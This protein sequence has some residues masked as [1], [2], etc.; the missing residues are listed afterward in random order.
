M[1]YILIGTLVINSIALVAPIN[2]APL[3]DTN[4]DT[5]AWTNHVAYLEGTG[6]FGADHYGAVLV[7]HTY[8]PLEDIVN[9]TIGDEIRIYDNNNYHYYEITQIETIYQLDRLL[10]LITSDE[11]LLVL[12]ICHPDNPELMRYTII[13]RYIR[14][15]TGASING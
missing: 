12:M 6:S 13:A 11:P 4:W 1:K 14:T 15:D 10:D 2:F 8:G 9:L 3:L 5:N 7:S